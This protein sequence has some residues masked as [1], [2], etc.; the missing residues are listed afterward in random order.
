MSGS[1]VKI[2]SASNKVLDIE[3]VLKKYL[4]EQQIEKK[5]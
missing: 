5:E 2:P 4:L 3:E 1:L